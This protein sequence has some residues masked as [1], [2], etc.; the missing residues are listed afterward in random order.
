[1]KDKYIDVAEKA[2]CK[3]IKDGEKIDVPEGLPEEMTEQRKGVF[4]TIK[5]KGQLRGCIG[6]YRPS[7]ENIALE[8]INNAINAAKNDPRF[9]PIKESEIPALNVSVDVL[10]EP[11]PCNEKDLNPDRYGVII[12]RG[13]RRGLLL[14]NLEGI[15]TKEEQLKHVKRKAGI[16]HDC[17]DY[18]LQRFEV[19]RH[20]EVK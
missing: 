12:K 16:P 15:D 20:S 1:M 3:Y 4:V 7:Q 11:E 13:S 8:I 14:P 6:T 2:I 9:P 18:Q 10:S 5:K 17:S 19:Q